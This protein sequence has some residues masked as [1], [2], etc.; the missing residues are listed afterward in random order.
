MMKFT[1]ALA[2]LSCVLAVPNAM[3]AKEPELL[4]VAPTKAKTVKHA[5][6]VSKPGHAISTPFE[7]FGASTVFHS[8]KIY[9]FGGMERGGAL[10]SNDVLVFDTLAKSWS[11]LPVYGEKPP[12]RFFHSATVEKD[13]MYI[14]GGTPCFSRIYMKSLEFDDANGQYV[15]QRQHATTEALSIE[16]SQGLDDV[17]SFNFKTRAWKQL[18]SASDPHALRCKAASNV[19]YTPNSSNQVTPALGVVASLAAAFFTLL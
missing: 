14:S 4:E 12:G 6:P 15:T 8:G 5:T 17:Y 9:S 11:T 16:H 3:V 13:T 7:R 10:P 18:K 2:A 1:V 19:F